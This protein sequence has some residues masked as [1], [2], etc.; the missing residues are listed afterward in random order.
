MPHLQHTPVVAPQSVRKRA[1][2][3]PGR[4]SH[5]VH[6]LEAMGPRVG[7]MA[8]SP[9]MA[10]TDMLAERLLKLSDLAG[11]EGWAGRR[12]RIRC[13]QRRGETNSSA[14]LLNASKLSHNSQVPTGPAGLMA[15]V[16]A[17]VMVPLARLINLLVLTEPMAIAS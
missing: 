1:P 7:V 14:T 6:A 3:S 2:L 13:P 5:M 8:L 11:T 15:T 16:P 12:R 9:A 10:M 17:L 4:G